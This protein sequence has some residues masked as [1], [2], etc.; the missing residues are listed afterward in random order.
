MTTSGP[1]R[2]SWVA[3]LVAAALSV[4]PQGAGAE[5]IF[6]S[7]PAYDQIGNALIF[8]IGSREGPGLVRVG[9]NDL[10]P[11]S[12]GL[13]CGHDILQKIVFFNRG[14]ILAAWGHPASKPANERPGNWRLP[15]KERHWQP[16]ELLF[17]SQGDWKVVR[18]FDLGSDLGPDTSPTSPTSSIEDISSPE[19]SET[20][21]FVGRQP[22]ISTVPKA[23]FGVTADD[24]NIKL[25]WPTK[26][27][28]D[29]YKDDRFSSHGAPEWIENGN[30]VVRGTPADKNKL[31]NV[32]KERRHHKN[33]WLINPIDQTVRLHPRND[34]LHF[35]WT[36][37]MVDGEIYMDEIVRASGP[38]ATFEYALKVVLPGPERVLG[39]LG[40]APNWVYVFSGYG[41]KFVVWQSRDGAMS[42]RSLPDFRDVGSIDTSGFTKMTRSKACAAS[43]NP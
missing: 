6:V 26:Q 37:Q 30:W 1:R 4:H 25:L 2:L 13:P 18:R 34:I 17:L 14:S 31:W 20:L 10:V 27:D 42:V 32:P 16:Y 35:G 41:K 29:P 38:N 9:L 19:Q 5:Q 22:S 3:V 11:S 15:D 33:R 24:G 28:Y 23:I 21:Y 36:A 7:K 12:I 39:S 43:W 8:P 40:G